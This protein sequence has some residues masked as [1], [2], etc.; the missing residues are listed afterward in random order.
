MFFHLF[1]RD[2]WVYVRKIYKDVLNWV[3]WVNGMSQKRKR[4][5]IIE[6]LIEKEEL[7]EEKGLTWNELLEKT[8]LP[9]STLRYHLNS[10]ISKRI[11]KGEIQIRNNKQIT[12]YYIP[13]TFNVVRPKEDFI[14]AKA[15]KN[16]KGGGTK[17]LSH[18]IIKREKENRN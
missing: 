13:D 10:L 4:R 3:Q 18:L 5:K 14:I 2:E 8:K 11:V 12:V 15:I 1:F 17:K 16:V 6:A 9:K 7:S